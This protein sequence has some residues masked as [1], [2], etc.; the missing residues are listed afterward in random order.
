[1]ET[2]RYLALCAAVVALAGWALVLLWGAVLP[3]VREHRAVRTTLREKAPPEL[4]DRAAVV[5]ARVCARADVPAPPTRVVTFLGSAPSRGP[6]VLGSRGLA[7][8]RWA[9]RR[10]PSIVFAAPALTAIDESMLEALVAHEVAHVLKYRTGSARAADYA[11]LAAVAVLGAALLAATAVT[12]STSW[13][14]LMPLTACVAIFIPLAVWMAH[15]R[16][17]ELDADRYAIRLTGDL[18]A[19]TALLRYQDQHLARPL[20]D[21]TWS[22]ALATINRRLMATHPETSMRVAAM[23]DALGR[24]PS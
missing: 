10:E 16:R 7:E 19:A 21:G 14:A 22:R 24:G 4:Q 5:V 13:A 18:D 1:M 11:V 20:S 15:R 3:L 23:T 17:E 9:P 2:A 12:W 8:T 6:G